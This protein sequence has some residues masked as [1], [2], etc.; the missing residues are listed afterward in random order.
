[1]ARWR[2]STQTLRLNQGPPS[3]SAGFCFSMTSV[4]SPAQGHFPLSVA[5]NFK[6]RKTQTFIGELLGALSAL[7]NCGHS[8][9]Q[10]RLL[11]FVDN[12]GALA[13]LVGGFPTV[14]DTS[15]VACADQLGTASLGTRVWFEYVES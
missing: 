14:P 1:M 2:L 7:H 5:G 10:H 4:L 6:G 12:R 8:I 3:R 13:A 11:H 15:A 9:R